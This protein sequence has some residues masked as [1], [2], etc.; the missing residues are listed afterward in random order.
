M[1]HALEIFELVPQ[2]RSANLAKRSVVPLQCTFGQK[3]S[4]ESSTLMYLLNILR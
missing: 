3:K 1:A 2:S 4:A